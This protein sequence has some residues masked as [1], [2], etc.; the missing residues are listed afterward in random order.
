MVKPDF[1]FTPSRGRF[2]RAYKSYSVLKAVSFFDISAKIRDFHFPG[3]Q[4]P[5]KALIYNTREASRPPGR[6]QRQG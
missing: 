2:I 3:N 4:K 5:C 1:D 6:A